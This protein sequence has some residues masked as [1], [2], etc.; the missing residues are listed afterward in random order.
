MQAASP[1]ALGV[2]FLWL[3]HAPVAH[4]Y[5]SY[6]STTPNETTEPSTNPA[7]DPAEEPGSPSDP[8]DFPETDP[9]AEPEDG[10]AQPGQMPE[11][12]DPIVNA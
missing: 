2:G 5:G 10:D 3:T 4:G 7:G 12:T 8:Q 1:R 11:S 6:M 9:E